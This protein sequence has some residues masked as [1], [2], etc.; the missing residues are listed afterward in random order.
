MECM[1]SL[2]YDFGNEY[3]SGSESL[4]VSGEFGIL[5]G[6]TVA[7]GHPILM[8]GIFV[9]TLWAGYLGWQ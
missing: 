3:N 8:R 7:L 2:I 1:I 9:Y 5:E 4:A 6:R